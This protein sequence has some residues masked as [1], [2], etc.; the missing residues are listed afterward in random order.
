MA[1][2][3][4]REYGFVDGFKASK[5]WIWK[6]VRECGL[7]SRKVTSFVT[8]RNL[9]SRQEVEDAANAFVAEV[10]AEMAR[11]P[12]S[13]FCNIDQ[14]GI[15]R[16]VVSQRTL[17]PMGV[18]QVHRVVQSVASLTHSYT[19]V[20]VLYA[21]GT[22]GEK[23]F[24]ILPEPKGRF[25]QSGYWSAPNLCVVAG[26]SHIMRKDQV[27]PFFSQ[28]VMAGSV[29]PLTIALLDSWPGFKDHDNIL[30]GVPEGRQLKVMTIPPGATALCQ[31]LDVYFFRLL[32]R[33]IRRIHGDVIHIKPDFNIFS[34]DNT[35]KVG[36][37]S[38]AS[39][40][41]FRNH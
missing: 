21:D 39:Y 9:R 38:A 30:S 11:Y 27:P 2:S 17:A 7:R 22:L 24:V 40:T 19:V 23:L 26:T 18:K 14:C 12:R 4:N 28:C 33:F 25:P 15:T 29:Q 41:A 34:R 32:K 36:T 13:A 3:V 8:T 16:E 31:P 10:R 5:E 1:L 35:L 20:P 37:A 6:F